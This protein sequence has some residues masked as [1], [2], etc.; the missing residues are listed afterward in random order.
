[1]I[2]EPTECTQLNSAVGKPEFDKT[3]RLVY[4]MKFVYPSGQKK[5]YI[6]FK[7]AKSVLLL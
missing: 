3:D 6:S 2:P 4:G 1:M 7:T 5:Y